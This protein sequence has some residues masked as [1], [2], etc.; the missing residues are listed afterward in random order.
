[1]R[2]AGLIE[3]EE[4]GLE[5]V[6]QGLLKRGRPG[7]LKRGQQGLLLFAISLPPLDLGASTTAGLDSVQTDFP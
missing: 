6:R 5:R 4:A 1:M 2:E 3:K 7:L